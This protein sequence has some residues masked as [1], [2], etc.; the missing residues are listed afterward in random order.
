MKGYR[1]NSIFGLNIIIITKSYD[2]PKCTISCWFF[3]YTL[4]K[5]QMLILNDGKILFLSNIDT[6]CIANKNMIFGNEVFHTSL[7]VTFE[8]V[9]KNE[10]NTI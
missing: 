7:I 6:F 8:S 5:K 4:I 2:T 10:N 1:Y 3:L 9:D